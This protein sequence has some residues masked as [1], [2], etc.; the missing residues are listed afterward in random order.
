MA[1]LKVLGIDQITGPII[2]ESIIT[3][4]LFS[5]VASGLFELWKLLPAVFN[6]D[7]SNPDWWSWFLYLFPVLIF[8]AW[9]FYIRRKYSYVFV[10]LPA[11]KPGFD[12]TAHKG[13]VIA[14]SAPKKKDPEY[15]KKMVKQCQNGGIE[16]KEKLFKL[17]SIGQLFKGLYHH[18]EALRF[19]WIISTELSK[20]YETC[21]EE[22]L[23]CFLPEAEIVRLPDAP[24]RIVLKGESDLDVIETTKLFLDQVYSND[25]LEGMGLKK[26]DIIVDISGGPKPIAIGLIF[27]ALDSIID[28]QYVEQVTQEY[29]VIP[30]RID[31]EIILDKT[32]E[33]LAELYAQLNDIK[34]RRITTPKCRI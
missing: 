18:E 21:I 26:S 32:S 24:D 15:I 6:D 34:K 5:F 31:H 20:P 12:V 23:K 13:I 22:F 27:G 4:L 28:I 29:N 25:N 8:I 16:G 9:F 14:L 7:F 10:P 3:L 30:L 17:W 19:V 1:G 11:I 33:Y 2:R